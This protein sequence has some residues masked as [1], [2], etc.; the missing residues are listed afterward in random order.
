MGVW[1]VEPDWYFST[2]ALLGNAG[3]QVASAAGIASAQL[4]DTGMMAGTEDIGTSWG[5]K[6]DAGAGPTIEG[7][8]SLA[9]AWSAMAGRIYQAGVNHAWAEFL[10]GRGKLPAPVNL[11]PRPEISQITL[12]PPPTSIGS[13]GVGLTD[14][15]P[16]LVAAVGV[17]VPNGDTD[18]L[19]AASTAWTPLGNV[20]QKV[21]EEVIN[22]I[23]R[24]DPSLPDAT[25]F[26]DTVM[27]F[28]GPASSLASD[29]TALG[30]LA[31]SFS[32]A[33][34][35]MRTGIS[36]EVSAAAAEIGAK[37]LV[38]IASTEVTG[39]ASDVIGAILTL[40]RIATA[41]RR[42]WSLVKVLQAATT[43]MRA[44]NTKFQ[45]SMKAKLDNASLIPAEGFERNKDGTVKPTVRYFDRAKWEAW[46]RYLERGGAHW[47]IDRWSDA[48][49]QLQANASNGYWFDQHVAKINGY[50]GEGWQS[51]YSDKTI[52]L[53]RRWD[54]VHFDATGNVTELVEN[55]SGSLDPRQLGLDKEALEAGYRVT[56]NINDRYQYSANELAALEK[57]KAEYPGRFSVN[58][59]K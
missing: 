46:Q 32:A 41:G 22:Q 7:A 2:A 52:V 43:V 8:A 57:L 19:T 44:F 16:G 37:A 55:K 17:P 34:S 28:N 21:V 29:A 53:G 50:D 23:R 18:R 45:P 1:I 47:D 15:L 36:N 26:Y 59:I 42:I 58:R 10:A 48:Y 35:A 6:Y 38:S 24:P 51:Q 13:S 25:A 20:L 11:P 9:Q 54:Y 4:A 5:T 39:G 27:S 12:S 40:R 31:E 56:Y 14:I 30:Q 3:Q 33:T 49:D